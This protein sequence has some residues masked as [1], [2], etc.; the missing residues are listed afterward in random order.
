METCATTFQLLVHAIKKRVA[1]K[2][3]VMLQRQRKL[4]TKKNPKIK[5][6]KKKSKVHGKVTVKL[7]FHF[8]LCE[9][10]LPKL[11][12]FFLTGK[13]LEHFVLFVYIS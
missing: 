1:T 9:L 7:A 6:T 10:Y 11:F 3:E 12:K 13:R 4:T 2:Q 8:Y 5:G